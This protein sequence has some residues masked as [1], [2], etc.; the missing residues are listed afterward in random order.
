[1]PGSTPGFVIDRGENQ[2][3]VERVEEVP[4]V[5][6]E[7]EK[8][9][10][11]MVD[12]LDRLV[13]EK[14]LG[15][16]GGIIVL[17]L[18]ITGIFANFLAPYGFNEM[19]LWDRLSPPSGQ[20]VLGTDNLGRDLL[21]R[22]IYGARISMFVGLGVAALATAISTIIGVISGFLGGKTDIIFQRFVDAWMCF[23]P[24]FIIL[25][26][27]AIVG[28]GLVQVIFVL[29]VMNGIGRSRVVRSAVIG[30]KENVY[31]EAATAIGGST[32]RILVRHILPNITAPIIILFTITVGQAIITEATISFLGFGIPPPTPSW[33]G[34]LSTSGRRYMNMA[35]WMAIWPG[36]AL[37]IVVYGINML[38]DALRD[39]LDPRLRGGLGRYSGV[40]TKRAKKYRQE[41]E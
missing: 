13:R 35:P 36:L 22:I 28:P 26:V 7:V 40:K 8:K 32:S 27:M 10:P 39:I 12:L 30:I 33:G 29:G 17:L 9:R 24:L 16:V 18:L 34:M 31:I 25:T 6:V 2:N 23:P 15:T 37:A 19:S 1:M 11:L 14:P 38:G 41:G 21:S 3:M 4:S 5:V 20:F